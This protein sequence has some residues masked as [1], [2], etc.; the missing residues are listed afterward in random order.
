MIKGIAVLVAIVAVFV[1]CMSCGVVISI[2][3]VVE[4]TPTARVM[5]PT[6]TLGS[7]TIVPQATI[8]PATVPVQVHYALTVVAVENPTVPG[9][10]SY[11]EIGNKLVAVEII[12]E[13]IAGD[14]LSVNP[15]NASLV[16]SNGFVYSVELGGRDGQIA[17]TDLNVGEKIKGWAAF[18]IP[19]NAIPAK[20]KYEL[21]WLSGEILQVD[22]MK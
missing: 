14:M 19:D 6:N 22:L 17:T 4:P 9:I 8:I 10:F 18:E 12:L 16:D 1:M 13:N 21:S 15:L 5:Q 7:V 20:I 3:G 11:P 2:V